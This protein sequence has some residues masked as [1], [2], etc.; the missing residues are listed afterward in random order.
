VRH[1]PDLGVRSEVRQQRRVRGEALGGVANPA[2]QFVSGGSPRLK[3]LNGRQGLVLDGLR[4]LVGLSPADVGCRVRI[5]TGF[6]FLPG[7]F[8]FL[9]ATSGL[10]LGRGLQLD[11]GSDEE[12]GRIKF[13]RIGDV[14]LFEFHLKLYN[15]FQPPNFVDFVFVVVVVG[16]GFGVQFRLRKIGMVTDVAMVGFDG[17]KTRNRRMKNFRLDRIGEGDGG[18]V[19]DQF[20][21]VGRGRSGSDVI[22]RFDLSTTKRPDKLEC[23]FSANLSSLV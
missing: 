12:V 14:V 18:A 4:H 3:I 19:G 20:D 21:F 22:K 11:L 17:R 15:F 6:L 8:R 5:L 13:E 10:R 23:L 16:N 9:G 2:G 1:Q 7:T